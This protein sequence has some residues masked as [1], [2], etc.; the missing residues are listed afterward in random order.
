M[1][2]VAVQLPQDDSMSSY[3]SSPW[4]EASTVVASPPPPDQYHQNLPQQSTSSAV[5]VTGERITDEELERLEDD[6]TGGA[7]EG[8]V[9]TAPPLPLEHIYVHDDQNPLRLTDFEVLETLGE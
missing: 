1:M 2:E 7:E 3:P 4:T 8:T 9:R 6:H 5:S